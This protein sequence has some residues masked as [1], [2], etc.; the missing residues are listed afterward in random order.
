MIFREKQNIK[1]NMVHENMF[2]IEKD[3]FDFL[4]IN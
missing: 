4:N 3:V 2:E 1:L